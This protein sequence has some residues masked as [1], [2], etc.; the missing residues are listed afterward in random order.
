MAAE[1]DA[2]VDEAPREAEEAAPAEDAPAA[3]GGADEAMDAGEGGAG[4]GGD[5]VSPVWVGCERACRP[6]RRARPLRPWPP[7]P[8]STPPAPVGRLRKR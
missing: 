4:E 7:A 2:H 8:R 1:G 5:D 6:Q 3:E